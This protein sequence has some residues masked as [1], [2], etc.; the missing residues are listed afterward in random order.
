MTVTLR[1]QEATD[2]EFLHGLFN[3]PEAMRFWFYEPYLTRADVQ[4]QFDKRRDDTT[5]RRFVVSDDGADVG[6]VELVE[7]DLLHRTCEFQIIVAPG[8]QGRGY[9][10]TATRLVLDY[11]FGTLNLH[12]VYLLVDVD[13]PGAIH[14]YEKAGFVTEATLRE[15][16]YA[17]GAY[18]DVLRM[19]VFGRD[20]TLHP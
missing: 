11:A 18:R 15:E 19:A 1:A 16:F 20:W 3:D 8:N 5:S 12:K 14:V 13:N 9:A 10:H 7:I 4:A 2:T 17:D 6:I